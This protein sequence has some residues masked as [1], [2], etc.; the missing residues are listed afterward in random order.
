MGMLMH[1]TWLEQ[2]KQNEKP[3]KVTP[4]PAEKPE[5]ESAPVKKTGG[6]PK[7]K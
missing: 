6:R 2:Q 3:K 4:A 1:H 7:K 5:K